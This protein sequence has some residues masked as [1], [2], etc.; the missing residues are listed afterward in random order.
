FVS[1]AVT[2]E[3]LEF[4][5]GL[6]VGSQ[7]LDVLTVDTDLRWTLL[8]RLVVTG[9]AGEAEIDAEH[10]RDRT[11]AGE[12]HAAACRA[13]IPTAE[14]KAAAWER[15]VGGELPN[16]VFRATLGGFV[17]PDQAELLVPYVDRYFAEVGRIWKEWS[18]DMSQTFAEVAYPFLVVEQS[19]I[20]RTESYIA[21][22]D[23]PPALKR[24]LSEGR[25]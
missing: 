6:L 5:H 16:A 13:A 15:I 14:A 4:V 24:L 9:K 18:S 20:D 21:D 25:D 22:N 17:E 3:D 10:E 11:A 23:P 8:R 2:D 19:T 7:A 12:R 1:T